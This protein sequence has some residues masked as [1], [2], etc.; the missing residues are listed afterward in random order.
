MFT[1]LFTP[2][3]VA[4]L[5]HARGVVDELRPLFLETQE[6]HKACERLVALVWGA[7]KYIDDEVRFRDPTL[8]S[9]SRPVSC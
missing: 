9:F 8:F 7:N 4:L 2:D 1:S 3:D 6:L 5:E